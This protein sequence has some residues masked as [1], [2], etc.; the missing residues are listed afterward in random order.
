MRSTHL[1][2]TLFFAGAALLSLLTA[3]AQ[4]PA[5][6]KGDRTNVRAKPGFDGEVLA[7][8]KKGDVVSVIGEVDGVG[9]DGK[10]TRSWSKI[11][12]PAKVAVWVYGPLLDAKTKTVKGATVNL[13]AGPGRNYSE[14]GKINQGA[15]ITIIRSLE[16]WTQIEP[17]TGTFAYVASSLVDTTPQPAALKQEKPTEPS[18]EP[19]ASAR[20][21]PPIPT[22]TVT[23][24]AT[25]PTE[26]KVAEEPQ[27][28]AAT[29]EP[30]AT[31][32]P[33]PAPAP[34]AVVPAPVITAPALTPSTPIAT[35]PAPSPIP[36]AEVKPRHVIR[37]GVIGG[38]ISVQAPGYYE[39]RSLH[40]EGVIDFL[41]SDNPD[42]D[43]GKFH[44]KAVTV[45][46]EE[47]RDVRWKTP[48][49][50]VKSIEAA[51]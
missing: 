25:V 15:S 21:A 35:T 45:S 30:A 27:L 24:P 37:D 4:I 29:S 1:K 44:G 43:L 17:P 39:L 3:T 41:V 10:T 36:P 23:E 51:F 46:G 48:V 6:I 49:L 26:T 13:R 5:V 19:V 42:L 2:A 33:A 9:A 20:P 11:A 14:L 7:S 34:A 31:A 47:W 16:D 32:A 12:L 38:A 8:L 22:K 18:P 28:K 50:K 40:A